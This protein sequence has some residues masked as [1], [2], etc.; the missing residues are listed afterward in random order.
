MRRGVKA[1]LQ[2][3]PGW[4]ICGEAHTG[5]EAVTKAEELKPDVVTLDISMP[6]LNGLEAARRIRKVS[7]N[8]EILI[9]SVHYSDQLIRD[10]LE[11]GVRGYIVKSDS[12]RDLIVAL[13][14]LADHKPFFTSQATEIMLN[15]FNQPG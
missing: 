7:P 14:A 5:R 4:E 13:E 9:L 10:I 12:D 11:A 2:S 8:S 3:H 6:D 1:L 15:N